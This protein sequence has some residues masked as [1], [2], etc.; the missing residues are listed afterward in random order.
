MLS[1]THPPFLGISFISGLVLILVA[2]FLDYGLRSR[3]AN[4]GNRT[5]L[6]QG[7]AFNYR[8]YNRAAAERGW[9]HWTVYLMWFLMIIGIVLVCFG[10]LGPEVGPQ[11][12][13]L[14]H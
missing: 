7:G 6:P 11:I 2:A 12:T 13:A 4:I 14:R 10:L 9:R 8:G 1:L 3:L 5:A